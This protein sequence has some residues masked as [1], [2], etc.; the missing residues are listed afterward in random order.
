M[1]IAILV[2]VGGIIGWLGSIVMRTDTQQEILLNIVVAVSGSLIA[3]VVAGGS[4][5][6]NGFSVATLLLSFIGAIAFLAIV[7]LF[8]RG[9]VR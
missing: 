4:T 6:L 9:T 3:G 2:I 1:G 5:I 8:R 7:N